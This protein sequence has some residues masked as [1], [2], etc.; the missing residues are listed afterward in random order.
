VWTNAEWKTNRSLLSSLL[1]QKKCSE[2]CTEIEPQHDTHH[3][4]SIGIQY[5]KARTGIFRLQDTCPPPSPGML[6]EQTSAKVACLLLWYPG[7][8]LGAQKVLCYRAEPDFWG[9]PGGHKKT[10]EA[11]VDALRRTI[12]Q[13]CNFPDPVQQWIDTA[14]SRQ[15]SSHLTHL[16]QEAHPDFKPSGR[17]H[18]NYTIRMFALKLP[19]HF[20][21]PAPVIKM[22]KAWTSKVLKNHGKVLLAGWKYVGAL[23]S[24][25]A[26]SYLRDMMLR[27]R[28]GPRRKRSKK[29]GLSKTMQREGIAMHLA[30]TRSHTDTT[31]PRSKP[32]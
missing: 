25:L 11:Y 31:G 22:R 26:N 1:D 2:K 15:G 27:L 28:A 9:F 6:M 17:I 14:L 8:T 16:T 5:L 24:R 7:L 23:A 29:P 3:M 30:G 21:S 18:P 12:Q 13:D 10:F 4:G 19:T 20:S 32:T